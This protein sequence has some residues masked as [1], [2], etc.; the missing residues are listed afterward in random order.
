MGLQGSANW[1]FVLTAKESKKERKKCTLCFSVSTCECGG[2]CLHPCS[3]SQ[4]N[5][6]QACDLSLTVVP[7]P[8]TVGRQLCAW[9][10]AVRDVGEHFILEK[11]KKKKKHKYEALCYDG[12]GREGGES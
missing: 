3:C 1:L 4:G 2:V 7:C 12:R 6:R 9:I 8:V 11:N 10:D 5:W